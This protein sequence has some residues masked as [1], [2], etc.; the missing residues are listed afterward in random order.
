MAIAIL[1][2]P[3]SEIALAWH[4]AFPLL[5]TANSPGEEMVPEEVVVDLLAGTKQLWIGENKTFA[6]LTE[7]R[8]RDDKK[9]VLIYMLGGTLVR[10]WY[11]DFFLFL[12]AW[13][14]AQGAGWLEIQYPRPGWGRLLHPLGFTR[15]ENDPDILIKE[16][17]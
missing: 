15:H 11:L 17:K 2:V 14:R 10:R 7:I 8:S 4:H 9:F 6:C 16:I 5:E 13:G 12:Y 3:V 1:K